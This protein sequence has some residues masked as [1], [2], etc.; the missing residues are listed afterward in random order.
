MSI[1]IG[2]A[3]IAEGRSGT[4]ALNFT[5]TLSP[6]SIQPVSLTYN[7]ANGTASG[8]TDYVA[9][10]STLTFSPGETTKTIAINVIGDRQKESDEYFYVKLTS[11]TSGTLKDSQGTG[12]I[13]N[14]DG[15]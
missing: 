7:T 6:A 1:S 2:D 14:D 9:K 4:R 3:S 11:N 15:R 8:G 12:T 13:L 10:M 5:V